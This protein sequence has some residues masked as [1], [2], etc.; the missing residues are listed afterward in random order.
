MENTEFHI[1]KGDRVWVQTYN[2]RDCSF[3]PRPA[4][5]IATLHLRIS[6]QEFPYVAL[7]YLDDHSCAC[8]PYKQISG[9]YDKSP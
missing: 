9:I 2:E 5:V 6:F 8:V 7:R 3:Y 4:V 1:K